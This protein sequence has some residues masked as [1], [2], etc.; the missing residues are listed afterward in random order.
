LTDLVLVVGCAS[1][2]TG[3]YCV[4]PRYI[5][6]TR[7]E[8][9]TSH[10]TI[11]FVVARVSV[12]AHTCLPNGYHPKDRAVMPSGLSYGNLTRKSEFAI[13]Y[14]PCGGGLEYLHRSPASRKR[15][16]KGYPV[17]RGYNWA[18]LFLGGINTGIWPSRLRES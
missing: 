10:P 5:T 9:K 12:V 3:S 18:T 13:A 11:S 14:I 4:L 6:L 7:T 15:Q 16:R 1:R 17:P 8:K 2:E